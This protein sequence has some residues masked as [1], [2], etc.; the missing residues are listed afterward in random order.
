VDCAEIRQ[1]FVSGA[2]PAGS[3]V[4]EHLEQCAHCTELFGNRAALGRALAASAVLRAEP[5][6]EQLAVT[7]ALIA[8]E[9]GA[10][11]Y[12]RSRPTRVRWMLCLGL[13]AL[14]LALEGARRHV[15]LRELGGT[16]LIVGL[17]LLGALALVTRSALSPVSRRHRAPRA[18]SILALVAWCVPCAL[19]LA[20]ESSGS[21]AESFSSS[22]FALRSLGC[23]GYGSAFSA[24]SFALLWALDRGPRVSYRVW[25]LA[26]GLVALLGSLILLLHCPSTNRA[27]LLAGHFS[28]GLVWFSAVSLVCW[29]RRLE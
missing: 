4:G 3:S 19:W 12:L 7:E 14:L 15:P 10:R 25:A 18:R 1:G 17:G 11:A 13:A 22:G 23:F 26:A 16:R 20:P 28:I 9:R 27:H 24:P 8:R 5:I 29:R 21:A 6:A 2:A